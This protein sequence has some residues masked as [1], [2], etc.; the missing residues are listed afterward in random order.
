M[1]NLNS[2]SGNSPVKVSVIIPF[3]NNIQLTKNCLQSIYEV[4]TKTYSFEIILV[5]DASTELFSFESYQMGYGNLRVI[6]NEKNLGFASSCN[7]GAKAANGN[8]LLFLNNDTL[9]LEG[10]LEN[11]VTMLEE[12]PTIGIVGSKLLYDDGRIQHAGVVFDDE[13]MPFR[14]YPRFPNNFSGVNKPREFQAVIGACFIIENDLFKSLGGFDEGFKNGFEDIDLCFRVRQA[15]RKVF[16]NP[17]SC[18]YH[19]ESQTLKNE[20]SS[21]ATN[22]TT[23]TYLYKQKWQGYIFT[24]YHI[25]YQEDLRDT[26][27]LPPPLSH[28]KKMNEKDQPL[29]AIWGAGRGGIQ[30]LKLLKYIGIQPTCF[31]DINSQK[32][33]SHLEEYLI[34][35]P[36]FLQE[37]KL[38]GKPIFI[39]IASIYYKDIEATLVELG[40]KPDLEFW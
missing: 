16:Y 39:M 20:S 8:Y 23:N 18:L 40:F 4:T 27:C 9:A 11:L 13:M 37:Q 12:D 14:I 7:L 6:R 30:N 28:L 21:A 1:A 31:I 15:G 36:K 33:G 25:F 24:D 34:E 3:K 17:K 10:W 29:I 2:I 22:L 26:D 19:L 32:W 5:D 38:K 35:S